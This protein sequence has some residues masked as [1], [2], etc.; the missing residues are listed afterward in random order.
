MAKKEIEL[1]CAIKHKT[2]AAYL[3]ETTVGEAWIPKSRVSD[4]VEESDGSISAIFIPEQLAI[5]KGLV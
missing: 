2:N 5:D 1:Q 3:V 4:Y